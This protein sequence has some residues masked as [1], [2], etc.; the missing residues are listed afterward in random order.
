MSSDNYCL[1]LM[2]TNYCLLPGLLDVE[3]PIEFEIVAVVVV[4]K[5]AENFIVATEKHS[6]WGLLLCNYSHYLLVSLCSRK[7][8]KLLT[9][10]LI[11]WS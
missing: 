7:E 4:H 8:V 10:L 5:P 2:E 1:V 9:S 3:T 11:H 6:R